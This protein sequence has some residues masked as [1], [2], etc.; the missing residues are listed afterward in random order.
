MAKTNSGLVAYCKKQV[1]LPY[2]FG[3]Y[4]NTASKALY[5]VKKKQYPK[6][7]QWSYSSSYNGKRVHDCAGLIKGYLWSNTPT[8]APVYHAN[9]DVGATG[10]YTTC[11]KKGKISSFPKR[12]GTLVFKG[13]NST[14][15]H[16][17]VYCDG[18][19]IHAKGHAYGVVKEKYQASNWTHWGQ[20]KWITDDYEPKP[21]TTKYKVSTISGASLALRAQP[22]TGSTLL[23]WIPNNT[24]LSV[25]KTVKGT[26]VGG[27]N[28]WAHTTYNGKTGYCSMKYLKKV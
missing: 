5:T 18:Y 4:G 3:T 2:F 19:I 9:Q 25:D 13:K 28:K 16:V 27:N 1:G 26:S 8:S 10:F 12:N 6:Y 7:Y 17:G 24:T 23:A 11:S 14:M 15:T 21:A 22:K 20:C